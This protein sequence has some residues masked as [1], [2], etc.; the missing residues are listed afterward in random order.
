MHAGSSSEVND[1]HVGKVLRP[2]LGDEPAMAVF[3]RGFGAE[4]ARVLVAGQDLSASRVGLAFNQERQKLTFIG[5]PIA[6]GFVSIEDFGGGSQFGMMLV[7]DAKTFA[8]E[9]SQI[10]ALGKPCQLGGV[11]QADVYDGVDS[12][13]LQTADE[14]LQGFLCVADGKD[15]GHVFSGWPMD[16]ICRSEQGELLGLFVFVHQAAVGLDVQNVDTLVEKGGGDELV[17]VALAVI[18]LRAHDG[19]VAFGSQI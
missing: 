11:A 1:L 15:G 5:G 18:T 10:I 6:R 9:E 19:S 16:R 3:G 12:C 8:Q 2:P 4:Q 13:L 17:P 14:A 7:L